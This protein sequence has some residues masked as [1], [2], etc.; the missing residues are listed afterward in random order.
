MNVFALFLIL[1][2]AGY[3]IGALTRDLFNLIKK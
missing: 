1:F 3:G 2:F